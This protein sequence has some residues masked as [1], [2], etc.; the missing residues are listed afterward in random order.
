VVIEQGEQIQK[1]LDELGPLEALL[2]LAVNAEGW[3]CFRA[4]FK[5][6]ELD[7]RLHVGRHGKVDGAMLEPPRTERFWQNLREKIK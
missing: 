4:Q 3:D 5:S 1:D 6:G 7:I 2:F